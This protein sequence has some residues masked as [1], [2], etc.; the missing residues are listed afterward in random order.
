MKI[1]ILGLG[2]IGTRHARCFRK[3]GVESIAGFDPDTDRRARFSTEF[4]GPSF[5]TELDA[6]A[7]GPELAV[8]ASPNIF[9]LS[10]AILVATSGIPMIIEKPLGV[11]LSAARELS[12]ILAAQRLYAHVGSNWKFHPA[13]Q[14]IKAWMEAQRIGVATGIQVLAGQ[15][16]PDWHPWEDYR[17]MY[18]ARLSLGGGAI[19]DTHEIDYMLWLM[20]PAVEFCGLKAKSGALEIETE[21]VAACVLRFSSGALGVLLTDYIQRVPRRRYHISGSKGTIEW[22]NNTGVVA[23]AKAG[24]PEAER[25]DARLADINDMYVAQAK[26][27]LSDI[28]V[29]GTPVTSVDAMLNVLEL[30]TRWH[31]QELTSLR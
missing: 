19:F 13:F 27:V 30:Q 16:L 7:W 3:L 2:S 8:I 18:A 4:G 6:I 5:S 14:T 25:V 20:G 9:H 22:D 21:D 12:K 26:R 23:L 28:A 29:G 11:D 15:W 10:Q 1:L 31:S 17:N 24:T